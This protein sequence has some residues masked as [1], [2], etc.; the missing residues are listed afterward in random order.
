[1][2]RCVTN[3]LWISLAAV[4]CS[5][6]GLAVSA[7][8]WPQFRGPGGAGVSQDEVPPLE[9]NDSENVQWKLELPGPGSSSPIVWGD[10]VFVT[11][12]SGYG[13]DPA[14]PGD[15]E[16][17]KRHVLCVHRS[18]GKVVWSKTVPASL[19]EDPF[20]GIGVP[21]HGYASNTPVTDGERLFVFLGKSG[22]FAFDM[23]GKQLWQRDVGH[24]SSSRRWGS[25]ASPILY[26]DLVIVNASEES[27]TIFGLS[28]QDGE[29]VWKAEAAGL[30]LAYGTPVV[31][32]NK[33]G[34]DELVLGVPGEVWGLDPLTGKLIWYAE[35]DISGNV[36]PSPFACGDMVYIFG[37]YPQLGAVAIRA[38]GKGDVTETHV[39]WS[40]RNSSY[41]PTPVCH[42]GHL[43]WVSDEGIAYCSD[44]STG[45]IIYRERLPRDGSPG[46]GKPVYASVVKAGDRLYA[47]SRKG[48]C[49]VLAAKPEFEL[50]AHNQI[51]SD[52]SDFH[53]T[54]ALSDGQM[55]LR[56][57]RFLYCIAE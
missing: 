52:D 9:W 50:L 30:E 39:A 49:Y 56:S 1:M 32:T 12:Y 2:A 4:L 40:S 41:I 45:D 10:R 11:C 7:S 26:K 20:R 37:G 14:N 51:A 6:S 13:E 53:G 34:A 22:V 44:A 28:K 24:E 18:N 48:G 8:E 5:G 23:D 54:P 29:V 16:N 21:Q 55:F 19:P 15:M 57:N 47:V 3:W 27:Q 25:A 17:L 38:G 35:V 36:S 43:Y 42:D 46:R 33:A 31:V